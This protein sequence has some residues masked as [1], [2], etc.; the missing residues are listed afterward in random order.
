MCIRDSHSAVVFGVGLLGW[1]GG[2]GN[3][4]SGLAVVGV[5][6]L[7]RQGDCFGEVWCSA[8][9]WRGTVIHEMGHSL[10]LPHN[11]HPDKPGDLD[12]G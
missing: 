4:S 6:S 12:Q 1:A 3:G 5:E 9:I 10:T 8:D 7:I 2:S 11:P